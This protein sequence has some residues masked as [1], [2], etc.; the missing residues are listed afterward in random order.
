MSDDWYVRKGHKTLGP[1][2]EV[3]VRH[4]LESGRIDPETLVRQGL[5]G[6]WTPAGQALTGKKGPIRP[7]PTKKKQRIAIAAG[8]LAVVLVAGLW[9]AFR[10]GHREPPPAVAHAEVPPGDERDEAPPIAAAASPADATKSSA[11]ATTKSA[12]ARPRAFEISTVPSATVPP[13]SAR[14]SLIAAHPSPEQPSLAPQHAEA[15]S[16]SAPQKNVQ[17]QPKPSGVATRPR[18]RTVKIAPDV[19]PNAP[20]AQADLAALESAALRSSTAKEAL[21]LYQQ[22]RATR[23]IGPGAADLLQANSC[24]WAINGSRGPSLQR[25]ARRPLNSFSKPT[26]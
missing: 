25:P 11:V 15:A 24:D 22:F 8:G 1:L 4:V 16:K 10:R 19:V 18:A 20:A 26:N 21:G 13:V 3:E 23:A 17:S 14:Q 6:P 2:T 12:V 5:T 7:A 9:F